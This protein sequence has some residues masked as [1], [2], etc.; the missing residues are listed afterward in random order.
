[1]KTVDSN[2]SKTPKSRVT[3]Q[4][5]AKEDSTLSRIDTDKMENSTGGNMT[6]ENRASVVLYSNN[7]LDNSGVHN[8]SA[9]KG[10]SSK[11]Q[12]GV[13]PQSHK[14]FIGNSNTCPP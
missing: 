14:V 4:N 3:L 7:E 9:S 5:R 12:T 8:S 2:T 10:E 11:D 13:S 1:M 6:V